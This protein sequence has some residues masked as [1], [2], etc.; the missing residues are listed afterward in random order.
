MINILQVYLITHFKL[1][2][3]NIG[4]DEPWYGEYIEIVFHNKSR[5]HCDVKYLGKF[6]ERKV[7]LNN[8]CKLSVV[9]DR[10]NSSM[11]LIKE[12]L[13]FPM[14]WLLATTHH[15]ITLK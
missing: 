1:E 9:L 10:E 8:N 15:H 14:F 5:Y 4:S 3:I 2:H 6:F 13:Y 12:V 7:E 11:G